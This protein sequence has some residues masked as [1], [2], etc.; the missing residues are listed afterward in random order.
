[1]LSS[2][3]KVLMASAAL[4][5]G[6]I[7]VYQNFDYAVDQ[8]MS[9][10][11][12]IV[13]VE[14]RRVTVDGI[15]QLATWACPYVAPDSTRWWIP[16]STEEMYGAC[17]ITVHQPK[18]ANGLIIPRPLKINQKKDLLDYEYTELGLIIKSFDNNKNA[19]HLGDMWDARRYTR[20]TVKGSAPAGATLQLVDQ[21]GVAVF[22]LDK[23]GATVRAISKTGV[24]LTWEFLLPSMTA[25]QVEA[26]RVVVSRDGPL[27]LQS[28]DVF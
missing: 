16:R 3:Q 10:T 21:A 5:T 24:D 9:H 6:I 20:I 13:R 18:D 17:E 15:S 7:F 26:L 22:T 1:M 4:L 14:H 27:Y 8:S 11:N 25:S 19:I 23:T 12:R 28:I 2:K